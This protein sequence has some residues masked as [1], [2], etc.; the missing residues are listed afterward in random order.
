MI[1]RRCK[2]EV[3]DCLPPYC[4]CCDDTVDKQELFCIHCIAAECNEEDD[5]DD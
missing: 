5:D 4:P 1:G 2:R 3:F